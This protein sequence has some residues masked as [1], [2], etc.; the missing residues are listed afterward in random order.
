MKTT[1][2]ECNEVNGQTEHKNHDL[3]MMKF[4]PITVHVQ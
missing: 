2:W 4:V 3:V 1:E